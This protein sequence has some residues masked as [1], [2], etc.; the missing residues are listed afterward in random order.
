MIIEN[1]L[2]ADNIAIGK[3][4]DKDLYIFR[5]EC[6]CGVKNTNHSHVNSFDRI[7]SRLG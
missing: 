2:S 5:D 6:W 1:Y 7:F 3:Q 4:Q